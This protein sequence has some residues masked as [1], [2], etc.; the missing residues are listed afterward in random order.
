MDLFDIIMEARGEKTQNSS[1]TQTQN[2]NNP[3]NSDTGDDTNDIDVTSNSDENSNTDDDNSS[4]EPVDSEQSDDSSD[5]MSMDD[6]ASDLDSES[7]GGS[8][9]DDLGGASDNPDADGDSNDPDKFKNLGLLDDMI[10]MYYQIKNNLSKTNKLLGHDMINNSV[11]L[12]AKQNL[13]KIQ[14]YVYTYIVARF[15][16]NTY[17]QNLY[18]FNYFIEAYK[19]NVE[20]LRKVSSSRSN[21][22][23]NN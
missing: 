9:T 2:D 23:T 13:M 22:Q 20:L 16:K 11:V 1:N 15:N 19:L 10:E 4:E 18:A 14:D 8:E 17:I 12:T 7:D 5:D 6:T 21:S 3:D